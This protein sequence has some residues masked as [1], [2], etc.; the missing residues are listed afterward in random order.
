[1]TGFRRVIGKVAKRGGRKVLSSALTLYFCL[2]DS[3][4]PMWAK[5]IILGALGYL[6]FPLDIIPDTIL[7]AGF[8]DDWTVIIGALSSV[9]AHI[10]DDHKNKASALADRLL[11]ARETEKTDEIALV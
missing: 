3:D 8:T 1:M 5:S 4:T 10:K 11:G 9:V 6:I 7:G 2:R